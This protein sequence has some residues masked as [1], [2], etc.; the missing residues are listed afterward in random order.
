MLIVH[1]FLNHELRGEFNFK[2]DYVNKTKI[3]HF[4]EE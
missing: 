4:R 2:R 3:L 1:L